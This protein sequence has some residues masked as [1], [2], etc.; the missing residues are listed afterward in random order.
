MSASVKRKECQSSSS[1]GKKPRASSSLGFQSHDHPGQG[2]IRVASQARQMVCYHCQQPGHMRRDCPLETG[3]K[4]FWD[5][6]IPASHRIG[7]GAVHS[8]TP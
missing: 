3:I 4:G 8:T 2:Q 6:T 7:A 5:S 1:S